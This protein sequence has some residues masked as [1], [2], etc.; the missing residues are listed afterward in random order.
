MKATD[1]K[2][3]LLRRLPGLA[4]ARPRDLADVVPLLD[5][6]HLPAGA[7]VVAE[8]DLCHQVVLVL[9][10]AA[11]VSAGGRR[12][13]WLGPGDVVGDAAVRDQ[14]PH[15]TTVTAATDLHVLVAGPS[16]HRAFVRHPLI[17]RH[18]AATL[19]DRLRRVDA[20]A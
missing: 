17:V 13:G 11:V 20:G 12:S 4:A 15:D 7:V 8:G 9:E 2:V 19:S 3:D 16:S 14:V 18:V 5:D 10:G 1:P 6:V